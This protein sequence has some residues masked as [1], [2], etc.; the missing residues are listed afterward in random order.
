MEK[1][2]GLRASSAARG[3]GQ[4]RGKWKIRLTP[5]R[6]EA[7]RTRNPRPESVGSRAFNATTQH[8][9]RR[10]QG[11]DCVGTH[12]SIFYSHRGSATG[13]LHSGTNLSSPPRRKLSGRQFLPRGIISNEIRH[14]I[15]Q[16]GRKLEEM[17]IEQ[18]CQKQNRESLS[19]FYMNRQRR[20]CRDRLG[21]GLLARAESP[22]PRS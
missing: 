2:G 17:K 8:G 7:A 22:Q 19:L 21:R 20:R 1:T 18:R 14:R 11:K 9:S 13:G 3:T 16:I 5:T 12:R 15:A 6:A 4:S 10:T